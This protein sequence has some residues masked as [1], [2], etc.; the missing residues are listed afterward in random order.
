MTDH[1]PTCADSSLLQREIDEEGEGV[2]IDQVFHHARVV[3]R[4][5]KDRYLLQADRG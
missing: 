4:K 1:H 2:W 5:D 3:Q